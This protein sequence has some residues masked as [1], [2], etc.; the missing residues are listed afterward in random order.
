MIIL[1]DL[2]R[3]KISLELA[4]ARLALGEDT[5]LLEA[6]VGIDELSA[7]ETL[8]RRKYLL[9][10]FIDHGIPVNVPTD[11]WPAPTVCCPGNGSPDRPYLADSPWIGF[12]GA[13]VPAS[14]LCSRLPHERKVPFDFSTNIKADHG[15]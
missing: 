1:H 3:F 8:R 10:R 12:F 13:P 7:S 9:D 5:A 14:T 6:I 11:I 4:L 2:S 15:R